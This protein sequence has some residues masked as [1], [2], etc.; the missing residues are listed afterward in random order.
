MSPDSH[1]PRA[2]D[3]PAKTSATE[4]IHGPFLEAAVPQWLIDASVQRKAE[5]KQARVKLPVWYRG[6]PIQQRKVLDESY[7]DYFKAQTELDKTMSAFQ[8]IDDFARPL[9]VKALKDQYKVEVDVDKTFLCLKRPLAL[10]IF[11]IELGSFEVL[12]LAM[13]QAALHNFENR[14]CLP[15]AFHDSSGFI[16]QTEKPDTYVSVALNLTVPEF[17]RLCRNLDIGAKYQAYLKSFFHP[18]DP[19][20]ETRLRQQFIAGQKNAMRAA[21]ERALL[22]KDILPEDHAMILSVIKGEVHPKI[23]N[24]PVWFR[25]LSL[26]R[27]RTVGCVVFSV[28]ERRHR[29]DALILYVPNDPEQPLMRYDDDSAENRFKRRFTER[30]DEQV[31]NGDPTSYQTF[32]S[33]FMPY[34]Q[35]TYYFSQFMRTSPDSPADLL[36]SPWLKV[37]T[38]ASA[39]FPF[40]ELR[41]TPPE[42]PLMEPEPD[43]F[44]AP[45]VIPRNNEGYWTDNS[46]LWTYL[47]EQ[48]RDKVFAD[49]RSHAV[50]TRDVDANARDAKLAGLLQ[51]GLLAL[52]MVS[53]FVP[54]LG[55]IMMAVMAGQLLYETI[56]GAIEWSEGDKHAAKAHLVDVAENLAQISLMVAGG[57]IF[58]RLTAVKAEPVIEQLHPVTLPNGETRL[59]KADFSGYEHDIALSDSSGPNVLGQYQVNGKTFI[60]QGGKVYE[61]V[62]DPSTAQW[63]LRHPTDPDAWQPVLGHNGYGAWRL[64]LEQPMSWERLTLLRRMGHIVD[65]FSD[66]SLLRLADISAVSDNALRKMHMD[67]LPPPPELRDAM[68]LFE[69]DTGARQMI[70]QLRGARPIDERYMY[71]LP[72][73]TEMPNWPPDRVLEISMGP[74]GTGQTIPY[75]GQHPAFGIARKPVIRVSRTQVL[76]G[77]M[78]ARVL[79]ALEENEIIHLLGRRAAQHRAARP[80]EFGKQL[81]ELAYTRQ[82][83][84][85]DSLYKGTEPLSTRVRSLQRHCP[86]LSDAAA[87]DVVDHATPSQLARMEATGRPPLKLLEEARWHVRHG[88]QTRAFVGLHS[89]NLATAES[90]RLALFAL[91]QLPQW[92]PLLRL[93]IRDGSVS[94]ALLDSIGEP[95]APVKRYLVKNGPF[96]QAFNERGQAINRVS[97]VEDSFYRSLMYALPDDMR[98]DL[99]LFEGSSGSELQHKIIES[100]HVHRHEAVQV[101]APRAKSFKPPV[102]VGEKLRGYHANGLG[103]GFN[104]TLESRVAQ[105][106]PEPRQAEAFFAQQRGRSDVQINAE[107][108][109]RRQE[110]DA[111]NVTL[112]Q[113]QA[114][115]SSSQTAQH[116]GQVAQALRQAWRNGPLAPSDP[117]AAR[118]SL[119]G[120]TSLP[121]LTTRFPHVRELSVTGTGITD[122][123]ADS[124]LTAFPNVTDLSMGEA[125][126]RYGQA[127]L[128]RPLT[129]LPQAVTRMPGL[130]RLRFSTDAR[131]LDQTFAPRLQ[132][133][134][135]LETLRIDYSGTDATTLHGMDLTSLTRLRSLRIDA[136]R[137]LWRWPE[138]VERLDQLERLDLTHTLIE[139]L[140]ESLYHGHEQL[141][142]GLSLDWSRV[143]PTT[144]RRAYDY[145]SQ[146]AGPFGHL[147][148]VHQMVSEFCRAELDT[149]AVMPGGI[150]PLA[151]VF[152]AAWPTPAARLAAIEQLR[153]D[154][155][156]IFAPFYTPT[157]R[158]GT[159]YSAPRRR[160][161]TGRNAELLNALKTS[162]HGTVRQRYGLRADVATFELPAPQSDLAVLPAAERITE[163]PPLPP[164]S[165]AHVRTVRLRLLDIPGEQASSFIR[166]F[167]RVETLEVSGN[168]F[169]ELPFAAADLPALTRL[170]ASGNRIVVTADVQQQLNGLQHLQRLNLSDNPLGS[171]DVGAMSRLRAVNLRSTH[172][173][174]WPGGAENLSR[175][176]WLD[177]RDNRIASLP[178]PVLSHPDVLMRTNLTGNVF[179][180]E[181]EVSLNT[182]MQRI[183]QQRG[184]ERGTLTRFAAEPVPEHFPPNETGWS[185]L[186]LL[187]PLAEPAAG[188]SAEA[189]ANAHVQRLSR[190][191]LPEQARLTVRNLQAL[192][193]NDAQIEAQINGWQLTCEAL[194]RQ[195]NGWLYTR[196]VRTETLEINAQN[197]SVA[198]RRI[199]DAWL[200][201]L[202]ENVGGP[203]LELEFDG[204]HT[205]DLPVLAVQLPAVT[206]LDLS[207]VGMTTRGSD[208]F[209][210]A[211]PNLETL[212]ISG[213][214]LRSVPGPVLRMRHLERL[215]MQYCDLRS[216][217]SLYPLLG[218]GRLRRLDI[219]YNEVRVFNPPDFGAL[220]NLDLRYN[221]LN[222]W[223]VGALQARQL[224][225][226]NLTGNELVDIPA[227]LFNGAHEHL[228][229]GTAVSDNPRLSLPA[230]QTMRR[231]AREHAAPDVMEMSRANIEA[232]IEAHVFGDLLESPD[233]PAGENDNPVVHDPHAVVEPVEAVLNPA[234]NVAPEALEPW[235]ENSG[236]ELAAQ[237]TSLWTQ[238]AQEPGHERFFQLLR[239]LR[240]TEDFRRVPADLRRRMW[241]VMQAAS[242]DTE[243][244]QLLFAGAETHGTC[245][246]GR[247][248]TFSDM[249]VRVAV[250]R[251]LQEI[252]LNQ[253]G[254]RGQALLRL[255]R[256]LFRLDRVET[257]AEAAGDG[258]DRAEV[259]L[260]YR[261][262]LSRGWDDGLELPGQPAYMHYDSPLSGEIQARTRASILEAEQTDA[263][264]ASMVERDYW[265]SWLQER[266]PQEMR[267]I[268]AAVDERRLQLWSMLDER[269][270]RGELDKQQYNRELNNLGAAMEVLRRQKQVELTRREIIDLK[271]F[272]DESEALG[273]LSPRPGPSRRP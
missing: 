231:Y 127:A 210:N 35:R 113:W 22:T 73:V 68:R 141:W 136:P 65:G 227:E 162:W 64:T 11:A 248:L 155:E 151:Q 199:R 98:A 80:S 125:G 181:G 269:L 66:E 213:N 108:E 79:A 132:A 30:D 51:F 61:Q 219:G 257:L 135:S 50:P 47:Y 218:R 173:Q 212:F 55:E 169:T 175:L 107:L 131:L 217:T 86:G 115:P 48:H 223:P 15:G 111:L 1:I 40:F 95:S 14:E 24:K 126:Q 183:E 9:L 38:Y 171:V 267:A 140:P 168:T 188:I 144:F 172:L 112:D 103:P 105:L 149:M 178:A 240:D 189:G 3:N 104:P 128:A 41:E 241:D 196:E 255:S 271:S 220:Q 161:A 226:L 123:N 265:I 118:L 228:L 159:R 205:G 143:T 156:A 225:S 235:L 246:D 62:L 116:R 133:L 193:L 114:G 206:T 207:R 78:P 211:F 157:L 82:S 208:G 91:E 270:E 203:G 81:A 239:L 57:A 182:A 139:T 106:Y 6:A 146:Y 272:A 74:E 43:P 21:A 52:N 99:G 101:L 250:Q 16:Q 56:E 94:G 12:K 109:S 216:A 209:L 237:R 36:S 238:L 222:E 253:M 221:H 264:P 100:A 117:E 110:W 263:L 75:G 215:E 200:D 53:M 97:R 195:L 194:T 186:D 10:G 44:I 27:H 185:F 254:L 160:W 153:A 236:P 166:A 244:R 137:A 176:N 13:L 170:D 273:R 249:E 262:G 121:A 28:G 234:I 2:A 72:L 145:V 174:T 154:Y 45:E 230:L 191:M 150:D 122:A 130:T 124:F 46:D 158:H 129:T 71:A 202:A 148:D 33:Q 229:Q 60:R 20:A 90:R 76:N 120:E 142:A 134:T 214:E 197:R 93:E 233:I 29:A 165:F 96:Y 190:I 192:G 167:S 201:D 23:G 184:L 204:L 247:I 243:L 31:K 232:M 34:D 224:R 147:V 85:F 84:I 25:D 26:M 89:E 242:E 5:F 77:E 58:N 251:A 119:V 37:A 102:R 88:R 266:Y 39:F 138:Y 32:F 8:D 245:T 259:R 19:H 256:Q 17:L 179:N 180:P 49:A 252:P 87:Q 92:S 260:R 67:H 42:R 258:L 268:N 54:V 83:A 261:I 187:L 7:R 198:A 152:D 69:A 59:W 18:A 164:G 63:R 177:L 163:L 4:S 70:E